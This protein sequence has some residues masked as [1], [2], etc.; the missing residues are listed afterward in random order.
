[1]KRTIKVWNI[2]KVAGLLFDLKKT[3]TVEGYDEHGHAMLHFS[4]IHPHHLEA[5]DFRNQE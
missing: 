1:V 3:F 2:N 5:V 4:E